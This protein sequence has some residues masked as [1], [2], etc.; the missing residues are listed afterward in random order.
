MGTESVKLGVCA[1]IF[2]GADLGLTKGGVEVE[3]STM[4]HEITVDQ[5]GE[6]VIG[7][8][9]TGRKVSAKVP[10]AETTLDN[11]VKIMPGAVLVSDGAFAT[12]TITVSTVPV[13]N[14][15]VTIKGL[16]LT[17]KTTPVGPYELAIPATVA[18][19]AIAIAD[20]INNNGFSASA[21]VA[22][23]VVTVTNNVRGVAGNVPIT[24]VGT[25]LTVSGLTGGTNPTAARVDVST[26][27]NTNL[28]SI[29]KQLRLR[30]VGTTGADDFIIMK[31]MCAGALNF[32]YNI[33]KERI[34]QADFKGYASD[35]GSLFKI[36]TYA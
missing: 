28:L 26:G 21:T 24:K 5:F 14:D 12:G 34:F 20:R 33:D 23:A 2:D 10:L 31:A 17:F 32:T 27:V 25:S 1:V 13:N 9:I 29:A 7:E 4:S 36:G 11:L 6:T 8:I 30:P 22:G 35:D 16:T 18:A 3:V 15:S 19:G